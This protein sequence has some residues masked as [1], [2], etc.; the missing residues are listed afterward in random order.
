[1]GKIVFTGGGTAGHVMPNIALFKTLR[2]EG[3]S[4]SYIGSH[5]GIERDIITGLEGFG[6]IPYYGISTGKLRR[7]F[8][9]KN[10]KDPFRVLRGV[11]QAYRLIR[12][13]RPD[14]VFSKGGF[15]SVPVVVA[16]RL[17]RVPVI[18]HESDLTPGLANKLAVPFATRVCATFPETMDHL[19]KEKAVLTG[20][21]IRAELLSGDAA[22]GRLRCDFVRGKPV[23]LV[24]GGSLGSQVINRAVRE[25]LDRLLKQMQVVHICGKGNLDPAL[26]GK[27]GYRQFEFVGPELADLLAMADAAVSRAGANA[28]FEFLAAEKPMLLIPLSRQASRG[29]QIQN[30][31]SFEKR[32]FSMT[33][34][35]ERL[36]P[37]TLVSAVLELL[38]KR[39]HI[40]RNMREYGAGTGNEAILALIRETA[41]APG[42]T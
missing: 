28:I 2:E 29:D 6:D 15:V 41:G 17:C 25:S 9:L 37:D 34:P 27:A 1:M 12:N 22:R 32:G 10:F 21:P 8:D 26:E 20:S 36:T 11:W 7:Y 14:L 4:L 40:R 38:D 19:P 35:E 30:A 16:A 24:V 31:A 23:L 39:E 3:W 13:I 18:I 42:K 5:N 33:L